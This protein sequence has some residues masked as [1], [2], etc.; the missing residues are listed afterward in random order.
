VQSV[1]GRTGTV[2]LAKGDV[3]L[4]SVDNTSDANKPISSATQT[5]L[6]GKVGTSDSRLSDSREWSADTISQAET[7]A[8]TATTRRAF[9]A[10]RVFQAIA[11]WWNGS[12]AKTKLDGISS[13][14]TANSTDAQ[15]RDRSTHTGTQLSNTISDLNTV[16][17]GYQPVDSDLT[18]LAALN[19]TTYGRSLLALAD[20]VA[21]R[22]ALGLGT[23]AT[24]SGTF[25]G[26]SSGTNTGDQ[27]TN[28]TYNASTR[29]LSSSTGDDVT[30]PLVT[31]SAAGLAS[32]ADKTKLNVAVI[33]DTTGITGADAVTNIVSLTQAEYD[34]IASPNAA[35]LYVITS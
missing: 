20:A 34:A 4:G 30:L 28:L 18:A 31:T 11:S 17:A 2:T 25:S 14:A 32:A 5:A 19:T 10:Q 23:L 3:G 13:G 16:L 27:P 22:T 8:G 26:T 6:D 9:T 1:A 24:Q 12:A 15:L 35:T 21:G 29:L 33:S 7:E